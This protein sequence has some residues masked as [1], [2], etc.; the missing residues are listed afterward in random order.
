MVNEKSLNFIKN[1]IHR[2]D[3]AMTKLA[4]GEPQKEETSE[5]V[6]PD[7]KEEDNQ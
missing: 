5:D 6:K 7:K 3:N 2:Y 4:G 1:N